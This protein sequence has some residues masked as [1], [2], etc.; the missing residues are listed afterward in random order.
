MKN[1]NS[2]S[3]TIFDNNDLTI[4]TNGVFLKPIYKNIAYYEMK[5]IELVKDHVIKGWRLSFFLGLGISFFFITLI[6]KWAL[7]IGPTT[8]ENVR[9]KVTIYISL[10]IM[11]FFGLYLLFLSLSKKPVIKIF[12]LDHHM[13]LYP[14]SNNKNQL[15]NI[16]SLLETCNVPLINLLP[17]VLISDT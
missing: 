8:I 6:V 17:P 10:F 12:T 2:M 16:V 13:Y 9:R 15:S 1:I 14:L 3:E 4:T 11:L 5:R 7:Y